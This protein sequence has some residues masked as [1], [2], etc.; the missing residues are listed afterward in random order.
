VFSSFGCV[1]YYH[2]LQAT[3]VKWQHVEWAEPA[4]GDAALHIYI[5]L[6]QYDSKSMLERLI[7]AGA[8]VDAL[9]QRGMTPLMS[10]ARKATAKLLLDAGADP[11]IFTSPAS[12]ATGRARGNSSWS[13]CRRQRRSRRGCATTATC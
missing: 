2:V 13:H 3:I 5:A 1:Q 11:T 7:A 6:Q 8:R 12:P 4:S 9:N 10:T